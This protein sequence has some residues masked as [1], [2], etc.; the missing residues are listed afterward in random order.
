[1][2]TSIRK[3]EKVVTGAALAVLLCLGLL[4]GCGYDRDYV[5]INDGAAVTTTASLTLTLHAKNDNR[6]DAYLVSEVAPAVSPSKPAPSDANWQSILQPS[7]VF[8]GNVPFMLANAPMST[9]P[10]P[11]LKAVYVWFK[12]GYGNVSD[13]VSDS[14]TYGGASGG[15]SAPGY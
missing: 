3:E 7:N 1:M 4:L 11:G 9:A 2:K 15:S 10:A 5:Q 6:V 13:P 8:D 12:D 14:V